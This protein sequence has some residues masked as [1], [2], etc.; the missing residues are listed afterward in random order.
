MKTID[1]LLEVVAQILIRC[2]VMGI[3][4]L[5][6]WWGALE[7]GG[8]LAYKVHSGI[9]PLT[10]PHFDLIHYAGMLTTKT[11]VSLLFLFP[12]IAIRLVIRK[13]KGLSR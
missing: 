10:R 13:R 3:A 5:F 6:I 8:D 2:A 11:M 12:F 1:E 4:V 7:W 9:I